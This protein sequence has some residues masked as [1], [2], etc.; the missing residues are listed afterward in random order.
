MSIFGLHSRTVARKFSIGRLCSF[1]GGLFVCAG[2]LDIIKLNK[3]SVFHVSIG[4][5]LG[6]F[7]GLSPPKPPRGGRDCCIHYHWTR[8]E[9][10]R[11]GHHAF[12]PTIF[13]VDI[14]SN[15]SAAYFTSFLYDIKFLTIF[16][17]WSHVFIH[18]GAMLSDKQTEHSFDLHKLSKSGL[19]NSKLCA[20]HICEHTKG[21]LSLSG[22]FLLPG[23]L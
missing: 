15:I 21:S 11:F 20:V 3:T 9:N 7:W 8:A 14:L 2:G 10:V 6:L 4:G 13:F 18:S 12:W 16:F 19:C 17:K 22:C 23:C 5:G 1:A